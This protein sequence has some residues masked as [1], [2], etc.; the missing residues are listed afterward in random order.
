[1]I[2]MRNMSDMSEIITNAEVTAPEQ[3]KV[4]GRPFNPGQSGNPAGRPKGARSRFSE[5]FIEDL[6]SVWERRGLEVLDRVAQEDPA[7][8]LRVCGQ[9][10]PKDISLTI[11]IDAASFVD[12]FTTARAML[13]NPAAPP[14]V[15]HRIGHGSS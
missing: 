3:R 4:I 8:L 14:R 12:K 9:L 11:G 15:R 5:A 2:D 13:G 6:H 7:A 10:M 1:M